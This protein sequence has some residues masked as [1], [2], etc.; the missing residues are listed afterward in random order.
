MRRI[1]AVVVAVSLIGLV[2]AAEAQNHNQGVEFG[3]SGLSNLGVSPVQS[4]TIGVKKAIGPDN[5]LLARVGI[6]ISRDTNEGDTIGSTNYTDEKDGTTQFGFG[7]GLQHNMPACN[8]LVPYVGGMVTFNHTS[9]F[10]EPS[11]AEPT[12]TGDNTKNTTSTMS[13]GLRGMVGCEYFVRDCLSLSG[14]YNF[15]F[16]YSSTSWEWEY[17]G[18]PSMEDKMSGFDFGPFYTAVLRLTAY[19][20]EG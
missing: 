18:Q 1:G 20:G 9:T 5:Y 11:L 6:G 4:G 19:W 8:H 14:E 15:G 17:Q 16:S 12:Q 13:F 10:E 2:S 7:V 3:F